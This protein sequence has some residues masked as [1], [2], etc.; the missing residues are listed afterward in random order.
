MAEPADARRSLAP[1]EWVRPPQ[2]QR[3]QQTFER[4]LDA[5]ESFIVENGV[6]ALTVSS[7]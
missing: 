4:I 1:L 6:Q 2:Q 3:S 5:A 7:T